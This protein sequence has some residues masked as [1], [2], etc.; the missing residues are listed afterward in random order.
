MF[1][2]QPEQFTPRQFIRSVSIGG[3]ICVAAILLC[4][5][6]IAC[7]GGYLAISSRQ[8]YPSTEDVAVYAAASFGRFASCH[9]FFGLVSIVAALTAVA[10]A[11]VFALNIQGV[12]AK[13]TTFRWAQ[14]IKSVALVLVLVAT[15][16]VGRMYHSRLVAKRFWLTPP[17]A[18]FEEGDVVQKGQVINAATFTTFL[19]FHSIIRPLAAVILARMLWPPYYEFLP[20]QESVPKSKWHELTRTHDS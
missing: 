16:I 4:I 14:T 5:T 8:A 11:I 17:A 6:L 2:Q 19:A 15:F 18:G 20:R 13:R 12:E 1:L 7:S 10:L 9:L 3:V